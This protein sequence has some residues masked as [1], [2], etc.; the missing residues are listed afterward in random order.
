MSVLSN[1]ETLDIPKTNKK[2]KICLNDDK[3]SVT[4][5]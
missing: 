3:M 2:G 1:D 4:T 5:H